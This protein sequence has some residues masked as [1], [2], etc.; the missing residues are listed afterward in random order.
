MTPLQIPPRT[1]RNPKRWK[2][3][4]LLRRLARLPRAHPA[5]Y[6]I[7]PWS[8]AR[9]YGLTPERAWE[10]L[11][12]PRE[13]YLEVFRRKSDDYCGGALAQALGLDQIHQSVAELRRT[14]RQAQCTRDD[15][16]H[17]REPSSVLDWLTYEK[18]MLR[19]H[20]SR[21]QYHVRN[22]IAA[23]QAGAPSVRHYTARLAR[24]AANAILARKWP[25]A[26]KAQ[27]IGRLL[28]SY[29]EERPNAEY[30]ASRSYI[31]DEQRQVW[32]EAL[33]ESYPTFW[34]HILAE[35]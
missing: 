11:E 9:R 4:A 26:L 12:S 24:D 16:L 25:S 17:D 29:A 28:R 15:P 30:H 18:P 13:R 10:L 35:P 8:E 31:S 14:R 33:R 6:S 21:R 20:V 22:L 27:A 5:N 2:G 7:F 23:A 3:Q 32:R 1:A 34:E 19:P